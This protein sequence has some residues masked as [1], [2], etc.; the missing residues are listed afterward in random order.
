VKEIDFRLPKAL[1]AWKLFGRVVQ[2]PNTYALSI[3]CTN[4]SDLRVAI[5]F[6]I[7][8]LSVGGLL[9]PRPFSA[10]FAISPINLLVSRNRFAGAS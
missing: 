9:H 6:L 10:I 1:S 5:N 2:K 4:V 3:G 7:S 8:G